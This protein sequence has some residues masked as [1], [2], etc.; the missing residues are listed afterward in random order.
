MHYTYLV[1]FISCGT[2]FL[3]G[4]RNISK[5]CRGKKRFLL[6]SVGLKCDSVTL[7]SR[8]KL[9]LREHQERRVPYG[10]FFCVF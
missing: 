4:C 3:L 2:L 8:G 1:T 5:I 6:F 7:P 10:V 9:Y